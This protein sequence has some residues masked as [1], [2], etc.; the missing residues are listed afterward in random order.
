MP[1]AF[2]VEWPSSNATRGWYG[3]EQLFL[4]SQDSVRRREIYEMC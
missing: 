3:D 4:T 1:I 2:V